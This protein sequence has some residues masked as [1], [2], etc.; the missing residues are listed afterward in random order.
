M[1]IFGTAAPK[2]IFDNGG[3]SETTVLLDHAVI[4]KDE[5]EVDTLTIRSPLSGHKFNFWRGKYWYFD[6]NIN[7]YKYSDP[8]SKYSNLKAFEGQNVSLWRHRDGEPFKKSGGADCLFLLKEVTAFAIED[9]EYRDRV[10]LRFES[11]D[12]VNEAGSTVIVPQAT[13]ITVISG[14]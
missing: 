14:E 8:L 1:G 7:L 9:V 10:V 3:G 13:D 5:P 11:I 2:F 12:Y 4:I 6:V